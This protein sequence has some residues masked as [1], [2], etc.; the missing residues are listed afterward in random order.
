MV[1]WLRAEFNVTTATPFCFKSKGKE[2]IFA[3]W[4]SAVVEKIEK[5]DN[6]DIEFIKKVL[7]ATDPKRYAYMKYIPATEIKG[8][9]I[10]TI[11]AAAKFAGMFNK[12]D[13]SKFRG[14]RL[15]KLFEKVG[16]VFYDKVLEFAEMSGRN[17]DVVRLE[18]L[19]KDNLNKIGKFVKV[20]IEENPAK[21]INFSAEATRKKRIRQNY[22]FI[23]TRSPVKLIVEMD[24]I[25]FL[26][27]KEKILGSSEMKKQIK[28]LK[29]N[30][31]K[32]VAALDLS[33][34]EGVLKLLA[35]WYFDVF[36]LR[37]DESMGESVG[38]LFEQPIGYY[39]ISGFG[40]GVAAKS[41]FLEEIRDE[42][43]DARREYPY[44]RKNRRIS[45]EKLPKTI[46]KYSLGKKTYGF[47]VLDL[48]GKVKFT[49]PEPRITW[50]AS[51]IEIKMDDRFDVA[52]FYED[53]RNMNLQKLRNRIMSL[54]VGKK[55]E[56]TAKSLIKMLITVHD[57][58]YKLNWTKEDKERFSVLVVDHFL[59]KIM[60]NRGANVLSKIVSLAEKR[61]VKDFLNMLEFVTALVEEKRRLE[62]REYKNNQNAR[63]GNRNSF[64]RHERHNDRKRGKRR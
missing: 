9:F 25:L 34:L 23:A 35:L 21:Y 49:P 51:L 8:A 62:E 4:L 7:S 57:R 26:F 37:L 18:R 55:M 3:D 33:S 64:R 43:I 44:Y 20:S 38:W 63:I 12:I 61:E 46:W 29:E 2:G 16:K 28:D 24:E 1:K 5:S 17:E 54:N 14:R 22:Y 50:I 59:K 60:E 19:G 47:G 36:G 32:K 56:D 42:K 27:I 31:P 41:V 30:Y 10:T 15:N 45:M 40:T 6:F 48:T 11:F 58:V 39:L 53:W 13:F 52:S